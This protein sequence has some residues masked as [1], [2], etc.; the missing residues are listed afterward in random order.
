MQSSPPPAVSYAP[1]VIE[2]DSAPVQPQI[3]QTMQLVEQQMQQLQNQQRRDVGRESD[4]IRRSSDREMGTMQQNRQN[5]MM[6]DSA[7][8]ERQTTRASARRIQDS[9]RKVGAQPRSARSQRFNQKA[10]GSRE[11][12]HFMRDLARRQRGLTRKIDRRRQERRRF[13]RQ[14]HLNRRLAFRLERVIDRE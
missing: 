6:R 1:Q 14:R 12:K 11:M 2:I 13:Q 9:I 10:D 7:R 4:L 3:D 5:D 8:R